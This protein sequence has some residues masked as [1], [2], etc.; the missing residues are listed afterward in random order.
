MSISAAEATAIYV[1]VM[2]FPA[3]AYCTNPSRCFHCRLEYIV[4]QSQYEVFY[5]RRMAVVQQF[6]RTGISP[7]PALSDAITAST[8]VNSAI[9][10]AQTRVQLLMAMNQLKAATAMWLQVVDQYNDYLS[11]PLPLPSFQLNQDGM[12]APAA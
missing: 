11:K 2:M 4:A 8:R 9:L 3:P 7:P 5:S 6:I 1:Q 10:N 12:T